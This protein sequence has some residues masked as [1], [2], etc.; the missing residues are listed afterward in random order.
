MTLSSSSLTKE[1]ENAKKLK[2]HT[3]ITTQIWKIF[4]SIFLVWNIKGSWSQNN[5]Y[6]MQLWDRS[7]AMQPCNRAGI[8]P[9]A[10]KLG[11]SR[12]PPAICL[13]L[14]LHKLLQQLT[15]D[16]RWHVRTYVSQ[17]CQRKQQTLAVLFYSW[18]YNL[19]LYAWRHS[20]GG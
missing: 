7:R 19:T 11:L 6:L 14:S 17:W 20:F 8:L 13:R 2:T 4:I 12:V 15:Q 18:A 10:L 16:I 9:W 3:H 5:K 1:I